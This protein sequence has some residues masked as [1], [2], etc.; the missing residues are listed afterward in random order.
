MYDPTRAPAIL[1]TGASTGIGEC[2]AIALV[3]LGYRVYA[4]VRRSL[5]AHR[6]DHMHPM[7]KSITLDVTNPSHIAG[8]VR[9]IRS[10]V[11]EAGLYAIVNNAGIAVA[12]PLEYL[13][14]EEFRRQMDINVTGLL[15]VTQ[16]FLPMLRASQGRIVHMGSNSG[17]LA[18]PF[19]GAYSASKFAVEALTDA[20]RRE[21]HGTGIHISV[22]EPG[23]IATPIWEK[24]SDLAERLLQ[25]LPPEAR[26]HYD[27]QFV[28]LRKAMA[29]TVRRAD[30]PECVARAVIHA[31]TSANPRTR[32]AVGSG[33]RIQ[34][35]LAHYFP[36][37][38][39]DYLIL[40]A[41]GL[42]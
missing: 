12:G 26:V 25:G 28:A 11:G 6:L 4:G 20:M 32:Y 24:S 3:K 34:I 30:P 35:F 31:I 37:R 42:W 5:D 18:A 8:A 29:D 23:A 2:C 16:A 33:S 15:A 27:S 39:V 41:M 40:K 14:L 10:E 17:K 22:I 21:L 7:L 38:W 19:T 13:P 36:D 1:V 9:Q